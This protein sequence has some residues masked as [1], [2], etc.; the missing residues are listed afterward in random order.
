MDKIKAEL[1][2]GYRDCRLDSRMG[3]HTVGEAGLQLQ[4][5]D[6]LDKVT[7]QPS[8]TS[9]LQ[10]G[11]SAGDPRGVP[12]G[13]APWDYPRHVA[14]PGVEEGREESQGGGRFPRTQALYTT[15]GWI[16]TIAQGQI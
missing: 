11:E 2:Q 5:Q 13:W 4:S 7:K 14:S 3:W 6:P 1:I 10:V 15:A 16:T 9:G 12:Q 8:S